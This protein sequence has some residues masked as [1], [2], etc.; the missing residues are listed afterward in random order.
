MRTSQRVVALI[1]FVTGVC[2]TAAFWGT[3]LSGQRDPKLIELALPV[4]FSVVAALL[5]IRSF[6]SLIIISDETIELH[7]LLGTRSLPLNKIKGRRR[8]RTRGELDIPSGK[9]LVLE[10]NDDRYPKLDIEEAYTFDA[11]FYAW[12]D[13]LPDLDGSKTSVRY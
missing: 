2:F 8:Y 11:T 3:A 5:T 12:F 1:L 9:H 6:R 7:G 10:P 13:S 4:L